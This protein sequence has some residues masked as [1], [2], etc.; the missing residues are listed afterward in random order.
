MVFD[1]KS[2][3]PASTL[4]FAI[5]AAKEWAGASQS[6]KD[7]SPKTTLRK[8][9]HVVAETSVPT[10]AAWR[11]EDG[12]AGLGWTILN[13]TQTSSFQL[14]YQCVRSPLMAE[15][16]ALREALLKCKEMEVRE[17]KVESDSLQLVKAVNGKEAVAELHGILS[18]IRQL[19]TC[20]ISLSF[21][22]GSLEIVMLLLII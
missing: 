18:D 9:V 13:Q 11:K 22:L 4:S 19:T 2:E 17:L 3:T 21:L 20:F 15:A 1:N 16:Q 14:C 5:S 6:E 8:E 10:D 7:S 12:A